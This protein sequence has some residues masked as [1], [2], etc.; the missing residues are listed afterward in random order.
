MY[1]NFVI[2]IGIYIVHYGWLPTY[3]GVNDGGGGAIALHILAEN[4]L[5]VLKLCNLHTYV[6]CTVW[7]VTYLQGR[8]FFFLGG[9][10]IALH[11]LAE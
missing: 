6:H 1:L 2:Y 7:L 8:Q 11:S 10:A 3:R 5:S 9:E 4:V